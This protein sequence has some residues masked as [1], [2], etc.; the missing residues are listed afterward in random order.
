[1]APKRLNFAT[2]RLEKS[3]V[4][5][6]ICEALSP[7]TCIHRLCRSLRDDSIV[8]SLPVHLPCTELRSI[9]P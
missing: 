7:E 5:T 4:K 8:V 1:M 9:T 2:H 3:K 6:K